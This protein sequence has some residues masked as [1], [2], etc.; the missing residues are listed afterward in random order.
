VCISTQALIVTASLLGFSLDASTDD[1]H[2]GRK[3]PGFSGEFVTELAAIR[4][5]AQVR[6]T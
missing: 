4:W 5:A 6:E 2:Q 1:R 3:R